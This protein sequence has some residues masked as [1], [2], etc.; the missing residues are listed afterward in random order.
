MLGGPPF[1]G[2]E[3][4]APLSGELAGVDGVDVGGVDV[5]LGLKGA[6]LPPD[7]APEEDVEPPPHNSASE[8]EY[9][10]KTKVPSLQVP[11]LLSHS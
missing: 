2:E 7:D 10:G 1:S 8:V 4:G 9:L 11:L 5:L 6:G 3:G